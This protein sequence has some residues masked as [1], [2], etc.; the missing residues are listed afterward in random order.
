VGNFSYNSVQ[1][2]VEQRPAHGLTFTFN[3]TYA[4]NI[5][6][7]GTYRS[8]WQIPAAALSRSTSGATLAQ[9]RID[10][11]WTV[12]SLPQVVHVFGVYQLPFGKGQ[13]G[14]DNMAVRWL[15]GGWQLS[16]NYTYQSGTPIA[17]TWSGA[18]N[19]PLQGTGMPDLNPAFLSSNARQNGSYGSGP[20]GT[21][22]CNLGIGTGCTAVQY[23]T[24]NAFISPVNVSPGSSSVP[25][26]PGQSSNVQGSCQASYLIGNAPRTAPLNLRNPGT[27]NIDA[28]LSRAFPLHF[29]D[30]QFVFEADCLNVWNKNTFSG[31]GAGWSYASTSF[32]T[33]TSASGARDW[34]FAGHLNF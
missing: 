20:N 30:A 11:S 28:R 31:P 19:T 15:A 27:Q 9:N 26:F 10:R 4:K 7:D 16:E 33:I 14:G 29:E 22:V 18:G 32:G 3:Y 2:L 25:C 6:D 5:G 12:I 17:V 34:Q 21:N 8:G 1:L 13:I 23:I 24:P